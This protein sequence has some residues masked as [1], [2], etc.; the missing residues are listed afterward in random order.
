[1]NSNRGKPDS[2]FDTESGRR[3]GAAAQGMDMSGSIRG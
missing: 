2:D 1:M 3:S